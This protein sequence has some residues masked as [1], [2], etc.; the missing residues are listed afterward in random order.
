MPV[1]DPDEQRRRRIERDAI[2]A[3]GIGLDEQDATEGVVADLTE[4]QARER[5]KESEST[6]GPGMNLGGV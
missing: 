2:L 5:A 3:S 6:Q 4:A 1:P